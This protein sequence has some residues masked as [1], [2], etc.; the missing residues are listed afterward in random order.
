MMSLWLLSRTL[1]LWLFIFLLCL[2]VAGAQAFEV[3]DGTRLNFPDEFRDL[4]MRRM[5][6]IYPG[7]I[8]RGADISRRLL[9]PEENI[10]TVALAAKT[11]CSHAV[12]DI[13]SWM[14]KL[15][16]S[17]A[18]R[19]LNDQF[20]DNYV[21]FAQIWKEE[22]QQT[23]LGFF[24]VPRAVYGYPPLVKDP[25]REQEYF[26]LQGW[27]L[28]SLKGL[29]DFAVTSAYWKHDSQRH[30]ADWW[31]M[32]QQVAADNL[33]D[34]TPHY[35]FVWW[36]GIGPQYNNSPA[37][38]KAHAWLDSS[39]WIYILDWMEQN[40]DGVILWSRKGEEDRDTLGH[41]PILNQQP[42]ENWST[43]K[44]LREQEA[45]DYSLLIREAQWISDLRNR[46]QRQSTGQ[47]E[48]E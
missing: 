17:A 11:E 22:N 48:P 31:S 28:S 2:N 46:L 5:C 23:K 4:G 13:E 40:A 33:G 25:G 27:L 42:F 47:V 37:A 34:D 19:L 15:G 30:N 1:V 41:G 14:P 26:E 20:R 29:V 32:A 16:R 10:R 9:P 18:I 43:A 21:R 24:N 35:F 36:R 6:V 12:I 45:S 44:T 3:F 38:D 39:T 8:Y 7:Q